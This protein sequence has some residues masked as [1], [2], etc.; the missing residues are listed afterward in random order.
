M[1]SKNL[2]NLFH[3]QF[4]LKEPELDNLTIKTKQEPAESWVYHLN[5]K[6]EEET[7]GHDE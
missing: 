4:G 3:Q 1:D 2:M 6:H 7:V 5:K